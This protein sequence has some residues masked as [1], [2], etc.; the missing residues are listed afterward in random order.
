MLPVPF[1]LFEQ[2]G[3]T[4]EEGADAMQHCVEQDWIEERGATKDLYLAQA[5]YDLYW[6]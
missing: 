3:C 1:L 2:L 5:G 4:N 6:P